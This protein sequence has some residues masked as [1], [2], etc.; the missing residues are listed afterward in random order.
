MNNPY[1]KWRYL[2]NVPI[3]CFGAVLYIEQMKMTVI[4]NGIGILQCRSARPRCYKYNTVNR[5]R[6]SDKIVKNLKH[7]E[8]QSVQLEYRLIGY[9]NLKLDMYFFFLSANN[10]R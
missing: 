7:N 1:F 10:I 5:S 9:G 6:S 2:V 4:Y 3:A 8:T